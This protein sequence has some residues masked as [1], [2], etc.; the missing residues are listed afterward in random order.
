MGNRIL[1]GMDMRNLGAT[2]LKISAIGL[3][4]W[5]FSGGKGLTGGYWQGLD[6][7]TTR[8]IVQASLDGQIS[9]FDTAEA[10]GSPGFRDCITGCAVSWKC[11]VACLFLESLLFYTLYADA[12]NSREQKPPYCILEEKYPGFQEALFYEA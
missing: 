9:F 1:R 6:A 5:Q 2:G 3:G 10:Y 12:K 7:N 8:D 11:A 4:C